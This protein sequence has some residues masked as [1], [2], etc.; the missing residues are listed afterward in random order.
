MN[1]VKVLSPR[2]KTVIWKDIQDYIFAIEDAH[3]DSEEAQVHDVVVS[4]NAGS[5]GRKKPKTK[6]ATSFIM[7]AAAHEESD[8]D[9]EILSVRA[10]ITM[11][12]GM[13]QKDK[14]CALCDGD[15]KYQCPLLWWKL[16]HTKCPHVW[17]VARRVLSISATSAPSEPLFSATSNLINK[18]RAALSPQNADILL[19]LKAN[20]DLIQW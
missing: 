16:N 6:G 1:T 5:T 2:E 19:F 11:E 10:T 7:N 14:G 4:N 18:Q 15:G 9:A 3:D 13:F 20:K 12:L 8:D 17:E